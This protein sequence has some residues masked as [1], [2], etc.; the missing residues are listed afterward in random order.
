MRLHHRDRLRLLAT[1][2]R[3][4]LR[5][6]L[7]GAVRA[8]WNVTDGNFPTIDLLLRIQVPDRNEPR[9][10]FVRPIDLVF[11][12]QRDAISVLASEDPI[13]MLQVFMRETLLDACDH[14]IDEMIEIDGKRASDPHHDEGRR[15]G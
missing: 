12:A 15:A 9:G 2:E 7:F 1:C 8:E 4:Q 13:G 5:H 11:S 3:L 10:R 6:P 14:E